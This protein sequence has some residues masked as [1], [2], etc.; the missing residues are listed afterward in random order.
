MSVSLKSLG[1]D[2]LSVA[3]RLILVEELWE[4]IAA[5]TPLTGA[6]RAELDRRLAD[7]EANPDDVVSWEEVQSSITARLNR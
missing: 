4:S 1:I 5:S 6:Q 3:E 7:H 2:R